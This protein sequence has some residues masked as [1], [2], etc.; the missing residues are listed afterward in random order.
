MGEGMIGVDESGTVLGVDRVALS[1]LEM[2]ALD[3]GVVKIQQILDISLGQLFD[4]A[5][6]D[7]GKIHA[8]RTRC[9]KSLFFKTNLSQSYDGHSHEYQ[10]PSGKDSSKNLADDLIETGALKQLSRMAIQ[11]TLEK[12]N[13]NISL[14][15]KLLRISRNTLYR[16]LKSQP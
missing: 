6:K 5:K 3:I 15:A 4:C 7:N 16:Y 13:G 9:S 14:A 8:I 1:L 12:T 11:K 10:E 2:N